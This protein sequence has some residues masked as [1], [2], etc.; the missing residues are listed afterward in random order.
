VTLFLEFVEQLVNPIA[1]LFDGVRIFSVFVLSGE[2][3]PL[4]R[5]LQLLLPE[6]CL[7]SRHLELVLATF[8]G[9]SQLQLSLVSGER[10]LLQVLLQFG[11]LPAV[12]A[13]F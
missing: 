8:L 13:I 2:N 11:H 5:R 10:S 4:K 7:F 1:E 9:L 3:P 12:V 6:F